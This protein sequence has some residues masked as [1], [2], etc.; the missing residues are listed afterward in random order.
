MFTR[1]LVTGAAGLL[2]SN[3]TA[4]L[5]ATGAEVL[6]LARSRERAA[7]LLPA[8][9]L[10]R[11]VEGDITDVGSFASQLDG[12]DAIIHAA[13]FR[14][15]YQVGGRDATQL[16]RVNVDAVYNLLHAAAKAG[17]PVVVHTSSTTTVG[18]RPSGQPSDEH[19]APDPDWE[20]DGYRASKIRAE[21]VIRGWPAELGV[22]VP[23]IVPAWMWGPGD[24][25]PTA[26]GRLFLAVARGELA[27]V[28]RVGS[29][30]ADA[31]DVARAA[32]TAISRGRHAH[33]YIV[34]AGRVPLSAITAEIAA[35]TGAREPREVPAALAMAGS[36][37]IELTARLQR[38]EP[39]AT[40]AGTR[41]LLEG[42]RQHLNS[43]R[44]EH[45]LGVTF[46]PLAQTIA[47]EASWY[48]H[49]GLLPPCQRGPARER[50]LQTTAP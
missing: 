26:S 31:R 7:R 9:Q 22:R 39:A 18:I 32:V 45:Q 50:G 21:K 40:R 27:A 16:Q 8:H 25:G 12:V 28:P 38:R 23:V 48:R 41:V 19:T 4:E 49:H 14:E 20:R 37:V 47:D 34:A 11:I 15:Y 46:R 29:H 36:S 10:L 30:I 2:G 6:A 1:V 42:D 17:V 24:A 3:V 43:R 44:A 33:R 13:Y 5:L 35:V